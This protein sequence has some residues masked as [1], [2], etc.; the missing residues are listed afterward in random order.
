[1]RADRPIDGDVLI[2]DF[3]GPPQRR[4]RPLVA[5]PVA[6]GRQHFVERPFQIDRGRP[7]GEERGISIFQRFVRCVRPQGEPHAIGRGGA[8]QRRTAHLHGP[9][10]AGGIVETGK[11]DG[12]KAMRQL[13]LVDNADAC[14]VAFDPDGAHLLAV[15]FHG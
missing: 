8:D 14:A 15:D 1:M 5:R 3:A 12:D 4:V 9:D 6:H 7:R 11:A 2:G 13:G 10:R